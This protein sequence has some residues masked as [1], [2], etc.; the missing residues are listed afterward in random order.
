MAERAKALASA[1]LALGMGLLCF[2]SQGFA[3]VNPY[4]LYQPTYLAP[5]WGY[6]QDPYGLHGAAAVIQAQ[7]QLM[8]DQQE[9]FLKREEVRKARLELHRKQLEQWL[10]ERDHLPTA[11]DER[12]R[13]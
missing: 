1:A 6:V 9:A 7:G 8:K 3:Q 2:S 4:R 11:E 12:E 13:A 10:W 5:A